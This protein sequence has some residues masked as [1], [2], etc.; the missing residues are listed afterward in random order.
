ML[1]EIQRR[2]QEGIRQADCCETVP[3][4]QALVDDIKQAGR[5]RLEKHSIGECRLF[6]SK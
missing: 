4:D 3:F 5:E 6:D 2:I 1:K